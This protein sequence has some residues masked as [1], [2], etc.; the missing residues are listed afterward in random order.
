MSA[1]KQLDT[2][3]SRGNFTV[4]DP[5]SRDDPCFVKLEQ[6]G[7]LSRRLQVLNQAR[8]VAVIE[9]DELSERSTPAGPRQPQTTSVALQTELELAHRRPQLDLKR[10]VSL[11]T[12]TMRIVVLIVFCLSAMVY[13]FQTKGYKSAPAA[14]VLVPICTAIVRAGPWATMILHKISMAQSTNHAAPGEQQIFDDNYRSLSIPVHQPL[15]ER[16]IESKILA[17]VSIN[18]HATSEG[19]SVPVE[20]GAS[21]DAAVGNVSCPGAVEVY[22]F[23]NNDDGATTEHMDG[24]SNYESVHEDDVV[25]SPP[26]AAVVPSQLDP[27]DDALDQAVTGPTIEE[28]PA[29]FV[30]E[31]SFAEITTNSS[32]PAAPSNSSSATHSTETFPEDGPRNRTSAQSADSKNSEFSCDSN[33]GPDYSIVNSAANDTAHAVLLLT[34]V[35]VAVVLSAVGHTVMSPVYIGYWAYGAATGTPYNTTGPGVVNTVAM[36]TGAVVGTV[37]GATAGAATFIGGHVLMSPVYVGK[38]V[39]CAFTRS[40]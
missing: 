25:S 1:S 12:W 37:A 30:S 39:Q 8:T 10:G 14:S 13:D 28:A 24:K 22:G 2:R 20:E 36:T 31:P 9:D 27:T 7:V 5:G 4:V 19:G 3:K 38:S 17:Q 34:G 15:E 21:S 32:A 40:A 16:R 29:G 33:C 11:K 35:P 26:G 6:L 18:E 23:E